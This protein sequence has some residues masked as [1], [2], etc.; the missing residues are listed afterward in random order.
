MQKLLT[1]LFELR[2]IRNCDG[3][4]YLLRWYIFRTENLGFFV[5]KF[6]S[7]DEDRALHD[8]P[9]GFFVLPIWR[10]YSEH[11]DRGKRRVLPL[12]GTR[13]RPATYRHRVELIAGKPAWSLFFRFKRVRVWGFWPKEGFIPFN[14]WWTQHC[15]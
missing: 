2:T 3:D 5:H 12:L 4:V 13:I 15:E 11:N 9:F 1:H 7:S 8:H 6:I 10:G 14:K